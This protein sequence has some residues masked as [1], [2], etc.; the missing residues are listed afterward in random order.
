MKQP[1]WSPVFTMLIFVVSMIIARSWSN[2]ATATIVSLFVT[3]IVVMFTTNDKDDSQVFCVMNGL[4]TVTAIATFYAWHHLTLVN[5]AGWFLLIAAMVI[6][7]FINR[8]KIA[9][10][11]DL[12]V[13]LSMWFLFSWDII[14]VTSAFLVGC[15]GIILS[16]MPDKGKGEE[17]SLA[18]MLQEGVWFLGVYLVAFVFIASAVIK[19]W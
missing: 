7:A 6:D 13:F 5:F 10:L 2:I 19:W 17:K 11:V 14:A 16:I 9:L 12:L 8:S 4:A 15:I 1:I 18:A 3:I